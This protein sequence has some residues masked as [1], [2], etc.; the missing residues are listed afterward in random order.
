MRGTRSI[1]VATLLAGATVA[2]EGCGYCEANFYSEGFVLLI[3]RPSWEEAPHRIEG[4]FDDQPF[5]CRFVPPNR[6]P[7]EPDTVTFDSPG[8]AGI[9]NIPG[10]PGV[11]T[12]ALYM[13]EEFHGGA[14]FRPR[15]IRDEPDGKGCGKRAYSEATL[16]LPASPR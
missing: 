11:V 7:C 10:D 14:T 4:T 15:Y 16:E 1:L 2:L 3:E 5:V 13:Y 9:L 8:R 6:S 12:V